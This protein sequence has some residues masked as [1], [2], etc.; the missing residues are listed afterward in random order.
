MAEKICSEIDIWLI[1]KISN[2]VNRTTEAFHSSNHHQ[3]PTYQILC[4]KTV[5][6]VQF[7]PQTTE[8]WPKELFVMLSVSKWVSE[9]LNG[10]K[11]S[12]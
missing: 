3:W 7:D 2:K 4:G 11:L 9:T 8:I 5:K 6:N 10:E 12:F 1:S